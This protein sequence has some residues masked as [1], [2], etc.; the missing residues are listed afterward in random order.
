MQQ[1]LLKII[2]GTQLCSTSGGANIPQQ[3][4]LQVD[5]SNILFICGELLLD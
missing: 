2:E 3:E 1:A 5:T 4:F